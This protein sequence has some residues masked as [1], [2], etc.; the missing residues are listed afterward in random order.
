VMWAMQ[1]LS[2]TDHLG[3]L[4]QFPPGRKPG[5]VAGYLKRAESRIRAI[6]VLVILTSISAAWGMAAGP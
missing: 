5:G 4:Q 6:S 2:P 1:A 3:P